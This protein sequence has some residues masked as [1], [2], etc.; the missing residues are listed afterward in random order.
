MSH[1]FRGAAGHFLGSED[2]WRQ[3]RLP[4]PNCGV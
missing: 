4:I 3:A 2:R 1:R